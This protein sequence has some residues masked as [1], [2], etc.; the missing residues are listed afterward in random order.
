MY[1][2]MATIGIPFG[3]REGLV[4]R[5]KGILENYPEKHSV[6]KEILQNADDAG[7]SEVHFLYDMRQH[8][9]KTIFSDNW[10]ILQ[11]P[12]LCVFNDACFTKN[13]KKGLKNLGVGS[14]TG[15][16]MKTGQFGIGFNAVYHITD[17]PA[18]MTKGERAALGGMYC[19]LD[20]H[21]RYAPSARFENPGMLVKLEI[22][23]E[24]FPDVFN[25]FL[26]TTELKRD[27]GT[28][29]RLPLRNAE[30]ARSSEIRKTP[31]TQT[32][33]NRLFEEMNDDIEES[34]LF[35][36]NI[37]RIT[38]SHINEQGTHVIL[39][40]VELTHS[41]DIQ[42]T[43]LNFKKRFKEYDYMMKQ[44]S[45][46]IKSICL[47]EFRY[48]H[49]IKDL[50]GK[51]STWLA[52]QTL[53][54]SEPEMIDHRLKKSLQEKEIFKIPRG[55]VAIRI[56][57]IPGTSKFKSKAFCL[58]PLDIETGLTCHVNGN[59]AVDMSRNSLWGSDTDY[60]SDVRGI[61]NLELIR[62][63]IAFA[64]ASCIEYTTDFFS[65]SSE[66]SKY[67]IEQYFKVLPD[68]YEAKNDF[69]K[70]LIYQ[71]FLQCKI[72]RL[73]IFPICSRMLSRGYDM[74]STYADDV[75]TTSWTCRHN[76]GDVPI[77]IDDLSDQMTSKDACSFRKICIELGMKLTCSPR[78]VKDTLLNV[79]TF[80][81]EK[82]SEQ[83]LLDHSLTAQT[84]ICIES[85]SPKAAVDYFKSY[86]L[87]VRGRFEKDNFNKIKL[88][89]QIKQILQYCLGENK[90][91][92]L[93]GAPL[94]LNQ[95]N[96]ILEIR[97]RNDL[98]LTKFYY[99]LPK[100]QEQFVHESLID[101]LNIY[102][103]HFTALSIDKF[104]ELLPKTLKIS[105]YKLNKP[106]CV[107]ESDCRNW[108][109]GFW[110]YIDSQGLPLTDLSEWCL[111]PVNLL[112]L[113]FVFPL[114]L[115][116]YTIDI[117]SFKVN[118]KLHS[119][120]SSISLP[121]SYIKS[122]VLRDLQAKYHDT[123]ATLI[124]LHFW[125]KKINPES[126]LTSEQC[127]VVLI[128]LIKD[129]CSDNREK[130]QKLKDLPLFQT[131]DRGTL[132]VTGKR[133]LLFDNKIKIPT[134]GLI[135]LFNNL[136]ILVLQD[137]KGL[138]A[139]ILYELLQCDLITAGT[140][141]G[142]FVLKHIHCIADERD[143]IV[144][145]EFIKDNLLHDQNLNSLLP[146][147]SIIYNGKS[148]QKVS[149]YFDRTNDIFLTMCT[150]SEFLP[151]PFNNTC[152]RN[153]MIA[154]GMKIKLSEDII[155]RF[156]K[157]IAESG[158]QN[159]TYSR[160][161]MMVKEFLDFV[162]TSRIQVHFFSD[163]SVIKFIAVE[164]NEDRYEKI[165][166]S[167]RTDLRLIAYKSA[168]SHHYLNLAWTSADILPSYAMP[169]NS[170]I[171]KQ[172]NVREPDLQTVV[173][174][175]SNICLKLVKTCGEH[176]QDF[177]KDVLSALYDYFYKHLDKID[178][179]HFIPIVHVRK[180]K[181]FVRANQLIVDL[182][183]NDEIVPYL[184]KLPIEYGTYHELFTKL[185]MRT[186][187]NIN[188]YCKVLEQIYHHTRE[189]HLSPKEI[190]YA[191]KAIQ[192]LM[193]SLQNLDSSLA[194]LEVNVLYLLSEKNVLMPSN[195]LYY[196]SLEIPRESL[197]GNANLN[198]IAKL[199]CLG[200]NVAELPDLFSMLPEKHRPVSIKSILTEKLSSFATKESQTVLDLQEC[201][202]SDT[203]ITAVL[204]FVKHDQQLLKK[205]FSTNTMKTVFAR[206]RRIRLIAVSVLEISLLDED[207]IECSS[208]EKVCFY[209]EPN[210]LMYIDDRTLSTNDW[211]QS[212]DVQLEEV[213]RI[214]CN[215]KFLRGSLLKILSNMHAQLNMIQ[216]RLT[217]IGM[218]FIEDAVINEAWLP[219]PGSFVPVDLY[220]F[221]RKA[222][223]PIKVKEYAVMEYPTKNFDMD[224][225]TQYI[226][227]I[228]AGI[229][230]TSRILFYCVN[231]GDKLNGLESIHQ[232]KILEIDTGCSENETKQD[233]KRSFAS[234][235]SSYRSSY[236]STS[237][238][239]RSF[240]RSGQSN[241]Q[242]QFGRKLLDQAIYDYQTGTVTFD[243][244]ESDPFKG[245]NWV[246]IQCQQAAEKA[247]KGARYATNADM[248][249]LSHSLT[250]NLPDY[251]SKL[252][253][254][255][256]QLGNICGNV[257]RMRYPDCQGIPADKYP[258]ELA[259]TALQISEEIVNYVSKKY[260]P[261]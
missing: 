104:V 85:I 102:T 44:P 119:V 143:R 93:C 96:D 197:K 233:S 110:A 38:L 151:H 237:S 147:L 138:H 220:S 114:R 48:F 9:S 29:F 210:D 27:H 109:N 190:D 159:D 51:E 20:P 155:Y 213:I 58:L 1:K 91:D 145:F 207:G 247:I 150:T 195:F 11:G 46:D 18:I 160:S 56:W 7:A 201:L 79:C 112:S 14:K 87:N 171:E 52:V 257:N 236:Q 252:R 65:M 89:D 35:L 231:A 130:I 243:G 253:D 221:I 128:Y 178:N 148:F 10:K 62:F 144:H 152:W 88:V 16:L 146:S 43:H 249:V 15:D 59:F 230:N 254:L 131:L 83:Y 158:L 241:P 90:W 172:L 12:S 3:Q 23:I 5:L 205:D 2:P 141:Y 33:M 187:P 28:W 97:N 19:V 103:D 149:A 185:G 142:D 32:D 224:E 203:F 115:C 95:M 31:F 26:T 154:A 122:R 188:S 125:R 183:E 72:R 54:F 17:A 101:S 227:V 64:Y 179:L 67:V 196:D 191:K 73:E 124:C 258:R 228:I 175:T 170:K 94:L 47:E 215:Y 240:H 200:F 57:P 261:E 198:F 186:D 218:P 99:L 42:R 184:I 133:L 217:N 180:Y 68:F 74:S 245:Y 118:S 36:L 229:T 239:A 214:I 117:N 199:D 181:T 126:K 30:M 107:V 61:W 63:N 70:E 22:L 53:G 120:L 162:Q 139:S 84:C 69:W 212:Y 21:C 86:K 92:I 244:I 76:K 127:M 192:G 82:Y 113:E 177:I 219:R 260:F 248:F 169:Y 41:V 98:I 156:A 194:D 116:Q 189:R 234:S 216:E 165:H 259:K 111:L 163:L 78:F 202:T 132:P 134:N 232:D 140:L 50:Q 256:L 135:D 246:C 34:L 108:F 55:G 255:A 209:L 71:M 137:M 235:S 136:N 168:I 66:N 211:L 242:I 167:N 223:H 251:D 121:T 13:D 25:S 24:K 157:R 182:V 49:E 8:Q 80:H 100:S 37:K 4:T 238:S 40:R 206:L 105:T 225:H 174:H 226:Y 173:K 164:K 250:A 176:D 45:I 123:D 6:L 60:S 222:L 166:P 75:K 161:E 204:R 39:N 106:R 129:M 77:L 81:H 193:K 208:T 153:F